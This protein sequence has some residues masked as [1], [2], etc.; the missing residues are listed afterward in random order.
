MATGST[1]QH[2]QIE[3]HS[4]QLQITSPG[5]ENAPHLFMIHV[6]RAR[7]FTMLQQSIYIPNPL[8]EKRA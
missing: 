5:E 3:P 4:I 6:L 1:S 7:T 8:Y 2:L